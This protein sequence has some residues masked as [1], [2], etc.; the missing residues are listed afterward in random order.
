MAKTKPKKPSP[1]PA[2]K[3]AGSDVNLIWAVLGL[4]GVAGLSAGFTAWA[5]GYVVSSF[6]DSNS[7][8]LLLNDGGIK[9]DDKNLERNLTT[10][11]TTLIFLRDIGYAVLLGVGGVLITLGI[12]QSRKAG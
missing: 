11:T 9:S 2:V 12:R 5:C 7:M 6:Q 1:K 10:A 4:V 8:A 3:T